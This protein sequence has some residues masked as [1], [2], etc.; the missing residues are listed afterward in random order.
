MLLIVLASAF[1]FS[2][3]AS[4]Y[5]RFFY[6]RHLRVHTESQWPISG[7]HSIMEKSALAGEGGGACPLP[8]PFHSSYHHEQS[9]GIRSC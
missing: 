2:W 3:P 7:E 8:T 5:I 4:T 9:C 1:L 6:T